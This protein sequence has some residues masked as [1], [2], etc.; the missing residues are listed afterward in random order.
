[1]LCR[2]NRRVVHRQNLIY[3]T[4]LLRR[5]FMYIGT[6]HYLLLPIHIN[7]STYVLFSNFV[8][9]EWFPLCVFLGRFVGRHQYWQDVPSVTFRRWLIQASFANVND[10]GLFPYQT[11]D[12]QSHHMQSLDLGYSRTRKVSKIDCHVLSKCGSR[13]YMLRCFESIGAKTVETE[14][15]RI[16][17][18]PT[19]TAAV[20]GIGCSSL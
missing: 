17:C 14:F 3:V 7:I 1:M 6:L 12:R 5:S 18:L 8:S 15:T 13:H 16:D 10:W 9:M 4:I 19:S 2:F 11:F 20:Y